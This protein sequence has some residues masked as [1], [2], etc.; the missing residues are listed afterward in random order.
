MASE[1]ELLGT[2]KA[3]AVIG[4]TTHSGL[5]NSMYG[6]LKRTQYAWLTTAGST[7]ILSTAAV[8]D[9]LQIVPT[10]SGAG[11]FT[12]ADGTTTI[13][14]IPAAS[15]LPDA[16]P[17]LI[18][19]PNGIRNTAAAGFKITLGASVSCLVSGAFVGAI[20]TA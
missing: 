6:R 11:V 18:N 7:Y 3:G 13:L 15:Y 5:D 20:T 19:F 14:S 2:E 10:S 9:S 1:F 4:T 16:R 12:L 17:H 8:I